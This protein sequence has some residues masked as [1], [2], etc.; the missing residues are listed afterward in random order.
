MR[1]IMC[2]TVTLRVPVKVDFKVGKR[3]GEQEKVKLED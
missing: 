3:W 2:D 1:D